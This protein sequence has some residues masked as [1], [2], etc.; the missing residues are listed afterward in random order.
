MLYINQNITTVYLQRWRYYSVSIDQFA[1]N[2][3]R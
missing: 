1:M 3:Y 2:D